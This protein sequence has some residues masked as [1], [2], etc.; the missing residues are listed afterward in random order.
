MR[1]GGCRSE[2]QGL[3]LC[4]CNAKPKSHLGNGEGTS[5]MGGAVDR[6][7]NGRSGKRKDGDGRGDREK[8]RRQKEE[9]GRRRANRNVP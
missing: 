2:E 1:E 5:E 4:K 6:P 3:Q 9:E 8:M 7:G